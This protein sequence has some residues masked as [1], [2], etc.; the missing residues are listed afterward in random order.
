MILLMLF[1]EAIIL[2]RLLEEKLDFNHSKIIEPIS[3]L[4][5][6]AGHYKLRTLF[7]METLLFIKVKQSHIL[8]LLT[9]EVPSLLF[10]LKNII[11]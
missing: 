2:H 1:L 10:L 8:Q 3:N 11:L 4:T 5:L 6:E 9:Q 7:M